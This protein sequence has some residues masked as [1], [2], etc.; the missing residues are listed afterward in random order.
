M[1]QMG[2]VLRSGTGASLAVPVPSCLSRAAESQSFRENCRHYS[3]L[4]VQSSMGQKCGCCE[5]RWVPVPFLSDFCLD[6]SITPHF[7]V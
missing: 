1:L 7:I 5:K 4:I 6:H 3:M 2:C